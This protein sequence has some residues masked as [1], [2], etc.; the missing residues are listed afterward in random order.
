MWLNDRSR[1]NTLPR[2]ILKILN[3]KFNGL[4]KNHA[5]LSNEQDTTQVDTSV[6]DKEFDSLK[7]I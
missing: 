2:Q 1:F 3:K 6:W 7:D 4:I 5:D